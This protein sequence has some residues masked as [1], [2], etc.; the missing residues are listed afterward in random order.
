MDQ[1]EFVRDL[2]DR[3]EQQ[4]TP[5]TRD[6]WTRYLKGTAVF[7]GVAMGQVR[8]TTHQWCGDHALPGILDDAALLRLSQT[9]LSATATEDRLAAMVLLQEIVLPAGRADW[10]AALRAWAHV[11]DTGGLAD[12]NSCDW[13][14]VKVLGPLI[15]RDGEACGRA[16]AAWRDAPGLWRRRASTVAFVNLVRRPREPFAGST[17]L[18]LGNCAALLGSAE[19]FSQTAVG[20]V[21]MEMSKARPE[22]VRAFVAAHGHR[23]SAE[24]LRNARKHLAAPAP[25][26]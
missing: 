11:F 26:P 19:R 17:D 4:A 12:W 7:R 18:V 9:L 25:G 6:W 3:L 10:Q 16:V 20:W 14:C 2:Q 24:A 15:E 22:V 5:K 1:A 23:M 21:L 8:A 13:F